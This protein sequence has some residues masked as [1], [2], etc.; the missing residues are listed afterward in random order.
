MSARALAAGSTTS[1]SETVHLHAP[2]EGRGRA[3]PARVH[4]PARDVRHDL[5]GRDHRR[6]GPGSAPSRRRARRG[7]R[8]R[9]R[10]RL[11]SSARSTGSPSG[12]VVARCTTGA[13][14]RSASARARGA[15]EDLPSHADSL[16]LA[17]PVQKVQFEIMHGPVRSWPLALPL[18]RGD[19]SPLAAQIARGLVERIRAGALA[20]GAALPSSRAL[21]RLLGVHRNTVLAAY[22]ELGRRGLDPD[23]A[24][25]GHGGGR[26]TCRRAAAARRP[27]RAGRT[28]R[29]STLPPAPAPA[30]PR[31]SRRRAAAPGRRAGSA[32]LPGRAPGPRL[33]PGAAPPG[34]PG[35][36]RRGRPPAAAGGPGGHAG[37]GARPRGRARTGC[38][39]PAAPRW[40]SRS[41][42][43]P[44]SGRAT[45]SRSR[46]SG[47][48]RRGRRSALA[49]LE[50]VPLPVDGGGARRR[51]RSR[52]AAQGGRLRAVY[53]TPHHQ[54]PT[55]VTLSPARRLALLELA[56]RERLAVLE[57]DYDNEFALRGAPGPAAGERRRRREVV[58]VGTLS[59]V[60]V[61]GLRMGFLAGPR[62][63]IAALI[64]HRQIPRPAG[65]PGHGGGGGRALRGRRGPAP[66]LAGAARLRGAARQ[67]SR[68]RS[69]P[70]WPARSTF[71]VPPGG[72]A[73]LVP[74]G[75]R[76]RRRRLG[77][78]RGLEH[79]VVVQA[80]RPV[81]VRRRAPLPYL[82]LGFARHEPGELAEAVRRLARAC[83]RPRRRRG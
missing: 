30:R 58:Y 3:G 77:G 46:R 38:S 2:V 73:F 74:G 70:S 31:P 57:D 42:R 39:S 25:A 63:A 52:H 45:P 59:K 64:A 36:R 47:T 71:A 43:G 4:H 83:P 16:L 40:R 68:P 65:R 80:G 78:A 61:P 8:R 50:L 67:R 34:E 66:G 7:S 27:R 22:G 23:C 49:G 12:V 62:D 17:W 69:A 26:P 10:A 54:Y 18:D 41:P 20:P 29:G 15:P 48:A 11:A 6:A 76:D 82:R 53:L 19:R 60:L 33:P 13:R 24:G 51:R 32:A 81:L 37:R 28:G 9:R 14:R 75:R 35:V 1:A 5:L 72:I 55:T 56:R 44:C 79:G 21:A